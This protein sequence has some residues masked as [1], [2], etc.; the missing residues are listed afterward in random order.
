[1][2]LNKIILFILFIISVTSC[3]E[4]F[5]P[6]TAKYDNSIY[7]EALIT[8]DPDL[9]P[10]V[11]MGSNIPLRTKVDDNNTSDANVI[12]GAEVFI[13]CDDGNEYQLTSLKPGVYEAIDPVFT[14]EEGK[15]YKIMIYYGQEVYESGFVKLKS[16]PEID[17]ISYKVDERK[18]A[19]DAFASKGYNFLVST[20]DD[21]PDPSYYRWIAK[22]TFYYYLPYESDF[23]YNPPYGLQPYDNSDVKECWETKNIPGIFIG[24]TEGLT[25]NSIVEA[26]LHFESQYGDELT[27]RY[28]LH[29]RQLAITSESY[30]FWE[31]LDKLINQTGGLYET[32]PFR[33]QG[34]IFCSTNPSS[35]V[36]GIFEVAGVSEK[37]KYF[38]KPDEFPVTGYI[39]GTVEVGT[40]ENPWIA[41][42][43]GTIIMYDEKNNRYF[44]SDALCFDCTLRGG[45][46]ERPAF[47]EF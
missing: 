32:Q 38:N 6:D 42:D 10:V 28:R 8:D 26:P 40:E 46:T 7:I 37:V 45:T 29:I 5:I 14:G 44:T 35:N 16:A 9:P 30:Y 1:M 19:D 41:I 27:F 47:W 24:G 12:D 20:H 36:T 43:G 13:I 18:V 25:E 34:N 33:L 23:I 3:I 31:D 4:P 17:S 22:A 39:C 15:S 21:S 2:H 11:K